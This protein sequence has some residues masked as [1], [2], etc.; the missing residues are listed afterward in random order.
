MLSVESMKLTEQQGKS[1]QTSETLNF[2]GERPLLRTRRKEHY[3]RKKTSNFSHLEV[4]LLMTVYD[5]L[6]SLLERLPGEP[7]F[8]CSH[9]L[10]LLRR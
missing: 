2:L 9:V 8:I 7:I 4:S 3:G 1:V 6:L 10:K 5:D